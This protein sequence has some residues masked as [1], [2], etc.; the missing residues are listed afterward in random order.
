MSSND[1]STLFSKWLIAP[2]CTSTRDNESSAKFDI[3]RY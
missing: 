2:M 1:D 3:V